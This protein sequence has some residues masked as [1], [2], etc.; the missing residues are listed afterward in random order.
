[1]FAC[2]G[3]RFDFAIVEGCFIQNEIFYMSIVH[4]KKLH[5]LI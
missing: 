5:R 4:H 3:F 2:N 1:M